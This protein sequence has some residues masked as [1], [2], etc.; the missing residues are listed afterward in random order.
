MADFSFHPTLIAKVFENNDA[1]NVAVDGQ[2]IPNFRRANADSYLAGAHQACIG[3]RT[4]QGLTEALPG[5]YFHG[6]TIEDHL[7][8][9]SVIQISDNEV[10]ADAIVAM[11][12][13]LLKSGLR[14]NYGGTEYAAIVLGL[15][16]GLLDDDQ[17]TDRI[18]IIGTCRLKYLD[19]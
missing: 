4:V 13:D 6:G 16:F 2:I 18:Q 11:I 12:V 19:S 8:E 10:G 9:I 7:I 3:I 17:F 1:L 15:K 14:I 5:S